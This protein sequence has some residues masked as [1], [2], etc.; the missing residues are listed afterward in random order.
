MG[1]GNDLNHTAGGKLQANVT[2]TND[3]T[4]QYKYGHGIADLESLENQ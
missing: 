1:E 2:C 3:T 4:S